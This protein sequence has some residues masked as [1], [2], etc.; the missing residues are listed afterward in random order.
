MSHLQNFLKTLLTCDPYIKD[1]R[2]WTS[3]VNARTESVV[4]RA[5]LPHK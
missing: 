5:V 3:S 1:V 4:S 2:L